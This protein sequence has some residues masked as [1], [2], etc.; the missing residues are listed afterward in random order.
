MGQTMRRQT[1]LSIAILAVFIP[2][3]RANT[4]SRRATIVGGGGRSGKCSIEVSVDDGAE[5]ELAGDTRLLRPISGQTGTWRRFQ[6]TAGFPR[7]PGDFRFIKV[8]GR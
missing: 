8:R 1:F 2:S 6:C 7:N 4:E 5:V 3:I